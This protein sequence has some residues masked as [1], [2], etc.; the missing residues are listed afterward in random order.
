MTNLFVTECT[1]AAYFDVIFFLAPR[2]APVGRRGSGGR[3]SH[4]HQPLLYYLAG[5]QSGARESENSLPLSFVLLKQI[6]INDEGRHCV[7]GQNNLQ[8]N[9]SGLHVATNP[10][11]T[12][13]AC[14]GAGSWLVDW[15]ILASTTS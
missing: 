13:L 8:T 11:K 2:G 10:Y 3:V 14:Y 1:S 15:C 6:Y 4:A 9:K 12:I 5:S 7:P